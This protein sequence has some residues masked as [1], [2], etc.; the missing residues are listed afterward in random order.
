[1]PAFFRNFISINSLDAA[2]DSFKS[3]VELV[4]DN[5]NDLNDK[6]VLH[7]NFIAANDPRIHLLKQILMNR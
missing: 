5:H 6:F 4:D 3:M 1:V 2:T 7:S